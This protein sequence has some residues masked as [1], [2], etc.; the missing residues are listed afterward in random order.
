M[1]TAA[2]T[3]ISNRRREMVEIKAPQQWQ[4]TKQGQQ[5]EGILLSIEPVSVKGKQAM[6]YLFQTEKGDRFT[7]LGTADLD[8][9]LHPGL[10]GHN[11]EITY[12]TDDTSFQ[13]P[14]QSAMK[15]FKVRASR[16]KEPG[17]E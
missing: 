11:V 9:K 16:E 10:I 15:V 6:E 1:S 7:C 3:P 17:F 4:F 13:K 12:E 5:V 8:K 14:G 2:A